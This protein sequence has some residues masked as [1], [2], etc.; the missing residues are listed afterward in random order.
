MKKGLIALAIIIIVS[1]GYFALRG[2]GN[3]PVST[4]SPAGSDSDLAEQGAQEE[5]IVFKQ[6]PVK[7]N[8]L[9]LDFDVSQGVISGEYVGIWNTYSDPP[10]GAR[11]LMFFFYP[12]PPFGSSITSL[13]NQDRNHNYFFLLNKGKVATEL[14]GEDLLKLKSETPLNSSCT[15]RGEATI[16]ISSYH[17]LYEVAE[18]SDY[19]DLE[20]VISSKPSQKDCVPGQGSRGL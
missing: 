15:V 3:T 10:P 16:R 2:R 19:A 18:T 14:F 6:L 17:A 5:S 8:S 12:D 7:E 4:S 9:F 1:V 20:E 11:S 13:F